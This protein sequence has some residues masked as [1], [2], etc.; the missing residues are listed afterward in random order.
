[1]MMNKLA[2]RCEVHRGRCAPMQERAGPHMPVKESHR[3]RLGSL[4][5]QRA[6]TAATCLSGCSG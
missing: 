3:S 1:M 5:G 2:G 6:R 4:T